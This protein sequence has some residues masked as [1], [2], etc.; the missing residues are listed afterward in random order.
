MMKCK[1]FAEKEIFDALNKLK[2]DSGENYYLCSKQG[3]LDGLFIRSYNKD[4]MLSP[5][6][7]RT[8]LNVYLGGELD[9]CFTLL[10]SPS[11]FY[12]AIW[13]ED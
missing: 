7:T 5:L 1:I 8:L 12:I 2:K 3:S 10:S 13:K 11:K 9:G 4:V 6:E